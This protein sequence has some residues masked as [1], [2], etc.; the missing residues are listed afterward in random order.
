MLKPVLAGGPLLIAHRGGAGLMPENTLA[1]FQSAATDWAADM[2]ELDV[3]ATRDGHCVVIHDATLDRTTDGTGDVAAFTLEQ[4]RAFDAGY[5]F[6]MDGGKTFPFRGRGLSIPTI[7]DVLE[8]VPG[9]RIT[10]EVKIGTAQKPLF[11]AIRRFDA[12]DRVIAAG[13]YDADRTMFRDYRGAVSAST[14]Q[15]RPF[16]VAHRLRVGALAPLRAD[17]IQIPE[18][19]YG[20]RVV[21][22]RLV[23]ELR[24]KRVPVHVWTVN[25][26]EEM[27]RLLDDGVD[28]IITDRPDRAARLF[29][30][31]FGRAPSPIERRPGYRPND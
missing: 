19:W 9:I 27:V 13:M 8:H 2:I 31:R 7:D 3:R 5:H 14:E 24:R 6:T 25:T 4:L 26:I 16:Y 15:L 20:Q 18:Y 11:D 10:V 22:A 29:Q 17:V 21:T 1:A 23:R 30:Q 28:G 12:T